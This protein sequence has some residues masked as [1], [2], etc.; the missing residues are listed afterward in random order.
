MRSRWLLAVDE[1]IDVDEEFVAVDKVVVDEFDGFFTFFSIV[2]DEH[3]SAH[4]SPALFL[5]SS[6][7]ICLSADSLSEQSRNGFIRE[8]HLNEFKFDLIAFSNDNPLSS[9]SDGT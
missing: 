9:L 8:K 3:R 1:L 5:F 7:V 2:V 6:S 4:N